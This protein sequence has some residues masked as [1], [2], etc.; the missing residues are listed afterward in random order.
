MQRKIC[1]PSAAH[2]GVFG[3]VTRHGAI[4]KGLYGTSFFFITKVCWIRERTYLVL[5]H[6]VLIVL[7]D[8]G[9]GLK[10]WTGGGPKSIFFFCLVSKGSY[11]GMLYW[12]FGFLMSNSLS[13]S[14]PAGARPTT[15]VQLDA[16]MTVRVGNDSE[17][18]AGRLARFLFFSSIFNPGAVRKGSFGSRIQSRGDDWRGLNSRRFFLRHVAVSDALGAIAKRNGVSLFPSTT[19]DYDFT[20]FAGI[21][22]K[23]DG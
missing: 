3:T 10:S 12:V 8:W 7:R 16:P 18:I 1:L 21:G 9:M 14:T 2:Q 11:G 19:Q 6:G 5:F 13:P 20:R 22:G 15:K 23:D 4:Q 17:E